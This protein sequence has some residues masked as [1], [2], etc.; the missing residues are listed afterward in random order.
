[1]AGMEVE[2]DETVGNQFSCKRCDRLCAKSFCNSGNLDRHMKVH[3]DVRP[4]CV[5]SARRPSP[6]L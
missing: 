2:F 3:N 1:M 6:R 4:S 5:M